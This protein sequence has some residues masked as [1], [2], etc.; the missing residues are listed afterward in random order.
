MAPMIVYAIFAGFGLVLLYV[1]LTEMAM[2]RRLLVH[3]VPV[4][5]V[6]VQSEVHESTSN[7]TDRK[8]RRDNSTT[9]YRADV[10]FRY[11]VDGAMHESD[12]IRPTMIVQ[13]HG[14]KAGAEE[15][16]KPFPMGATV[17]AW[18]DPKNPD[19][20]FLV[21]EGWAGPMVFAV[22]GVLLPPIA[23]LASRLA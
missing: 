14:S 19:R 13:G 8:Q 9:S 7:N 23:W 5:A 18:V 4:D 12:T 1:G 15:E 10:K 21:K 20:A 22:L 3:S 2:Q 17:Q 16:L 11:M 6:I